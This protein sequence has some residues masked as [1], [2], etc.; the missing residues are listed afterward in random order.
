MRIGVTGSTGLIGTALVPALTGHDVVRFVRRAPQG[1][2]ERQWDGVSLD[3]KA[4]DDLDAVIHLAG[5][6]VADKR[7][8]ES[9]KREVLDSRVKGT[10]A[11]AKAVASAG[12]P[13]LLSASAV[14][15]YGDTGDIPTDETAGPGRGFLA[16]VC[17]QWEA[18]TA[19]ADDVARVVHLRT[20]IVLSKEGGALKKQLPIF[21]AGLGAPL[22]SGKQWVPW[23][24]IDD[25]VAAITHLL[26]SDVA[27]P[28]NL[29]GPAV[30]TNKDFTRALGRALHRPTAPLAVPGFALKVALGDFAE[31]GV[32]A[33][34]RL[35]PAV[36]KKSGFTW[37]HDEVGA[38]LRAVLSR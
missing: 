1:A 11:V 10:T 25:E 28:V 31:E 18:A 9:R 3:P 8:S 21:K 20:G 4:V 7:W 35:L 13:V 14:G 2:S 19:A 24:S 33:G 29:V 17:V 12:V 22:G 5:A 32:L 16:D 26:T 15:Y 6:G 36:L 34:Q 38:A 23:I 37:Q 27:G 30:V